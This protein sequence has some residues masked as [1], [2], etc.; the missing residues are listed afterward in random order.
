M[1]NVIHP[2]ELEFDE[3]IAS[4]ETVF[5][6]FFA[7]WCGPCKML[8]PQIEQLANEYKEKLPV[9]KVDID[10]QLALAA[11]YDIQTIPTLVIFKNGKIHRQSVGFQPY[12]Q[13]KKLLEY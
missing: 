10:Q 3:I 7:S 6:D 5:V 2:N 4:N 12:D 8:A 1:S 11:R 13:L 9:L